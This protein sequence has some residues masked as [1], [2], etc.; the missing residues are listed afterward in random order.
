MAKLLMSMLLWMLAAVLSA[1][2]DTIKSRWDRSIWSAIPD[3]KVILL[4]FIIIPTGKIKKWLKGDWRN[5]YVDGDPRKG[6]RKLFEYFFGWEP[7]GFL[8]RIPVPDQLADAW[9]FFKMIML[10]LFFVNIIFKV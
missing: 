4:G 9:H 3:G 2:M 10:L 8:G 1:C 6:R 5:K 7:R